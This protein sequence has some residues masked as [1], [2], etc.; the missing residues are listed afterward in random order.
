MSRILIIDD[1]KVI[2][3]VVSEKLKAIQEEV[4]G[5]AGDGDEGVE[6]FKQLRP[7]LVLLDVTMPNKDGRECLKEILAIDPRASVIMLSA[8]NSSEVIKECL[9]LGAKAFI[10]KS[11]I[12]EKDGLAKELARY[13]RKKAA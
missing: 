11:V 13:L 4:V 3:R 1:S 6:K 2:Q 9:A 8:L 5:L 7:D 10:D 12:T